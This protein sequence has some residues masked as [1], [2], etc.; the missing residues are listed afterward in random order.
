MEGQREQRHPGGGR[1]RGGNRGASRGG[2]NKSSRYNEHPVDAG[3]RDDRPSSARG[4]RGGGF[5]GRD[6]RPTTSQ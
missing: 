5:R 3:P 6:R 4:N 1:G 2:F